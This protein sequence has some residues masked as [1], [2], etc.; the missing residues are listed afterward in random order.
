MAQC[1]NHMFFMKIYANE[2]WN[3]KF[4]MFY[5]KLRHPYALCRL[6]LSSLTNLWNRH[7]IFRGFASDKINTKN[8]KIW[9]NKYIPEFHIFIYLLMKQFLKLF[10][11]YK[12]NFV[13]EILLIIIVNQIF[14]LLIHIC[15]S[16]YLHYL[17][18]YRCIFPFFF[19]LFVSHKVWWIM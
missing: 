13:F 18:I 17:W 7:A 12:N 4:N 8:V 11:I 2:L 5:D 1:K 19:M 6:Q 16:S 3:K 15:E 14:K 9:R 10:I